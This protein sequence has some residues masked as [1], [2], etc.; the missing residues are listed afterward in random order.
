MRCLG[1]VLFAALMQI[2]L[3]FTS[4]H[5]QAQDVD[6]ELVMAV[7]GSRSVDQGEYILQLGG[8]A[9]AF[10][11]TSIHD[12]ILSGAHGRV[13]VA[14][15]VWA[16]GNRPKIKTDWYILD[17]AQSANQFA[18]VVSELHRKDRITQGMIGTRTAI[19]DGIDHAIRMIKGNQITAA[20]SIIDVSGDGIA[21]RQWVPGALM[22]PE[23]RIKATTSNI[24]INGLAILTD[25]PGLDIWYRSNVITGPGAFV[26][27]A[28]NFESFSEAFFFFFCRE[29]SNPIAQN[30]PIFDHGYNDNFAEH[31]F[32][33]HFFDK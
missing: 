6:I 8:I 29:L 24:T 9:S 19:G 32:T 20:K 13:A 31:Q 21:T 26:I 25:F 23:A 28:V 22:L 16:S 7:D 27:E 2:A 14:L 4:I 15:M 3:F 30:T 33:A 18:D 5:A 11:D 17:S 1:R 12:A 10:R